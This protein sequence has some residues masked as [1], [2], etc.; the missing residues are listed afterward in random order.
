[1]TLEEKCRELLAVM[2]ERDYVPRS[3]YNAVMKE[4][5]DAELELKKVRQAAHDEITALTNENIRLR[6]QAH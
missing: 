4:L 6:N 5:A 2:N 1:M 3:R